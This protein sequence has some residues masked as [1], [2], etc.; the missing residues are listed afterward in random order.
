MPRRED[1]TPSRKD[2]KNTK[3]TTNGR[4]MLNTNKASLLSVFA[5][6]REIFFVSFCVIFYPAARGPSLW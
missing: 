3:N 2:A 5:A 6:L 1:L 4:G